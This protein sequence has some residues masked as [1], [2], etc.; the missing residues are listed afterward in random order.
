MPETTKCETCQKRL[1][2]GNRA[3]NGTQCATCAAP[4]PEPRPEPTHCAKGHPRAEHWVVTKTGGRCRVCANEASRA[5][6]A[7]QR[8]GN[9]KVLTPEARGY[10]E[11][12]FDKHHGAGDPEDLVQQVGAYFAA[13]RA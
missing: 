5:S 3:E 8:T 9:P 13:H 10:L 2:K 11:Q 12:L 6:R 7:K 4:A 1:T